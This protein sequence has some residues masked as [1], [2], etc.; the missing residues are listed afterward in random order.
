M[1]LEGLRVVIQGS[2]VHSRGWKETQ[3][4]GERR[5]LGRFKVMWGVRTWKARWSSDS[6]GSWTQGQVTTGRVSRKCT[7]G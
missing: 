3:Q 1:R 4:G 5:D 2:A 6:D 7:H